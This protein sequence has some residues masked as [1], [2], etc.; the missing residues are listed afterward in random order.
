MSNQ[1][2][3]QS[4]KQWPPFF[5]NSEF[6]IN[7]I[8]NNNNQSEPKEIKGFLNTLDDE[9]GDS[10][11]KI[12]ESTDLSKIFQS[13][14]SKELDEKTQ[15]SFSNLSLEKKIEDDKKIEEEK[16]ERQ[17]NISFN[18]SNGNKKSFSVLFNF[19][20]GKD[21]ISKIDPKKSFND[22]CLAKL[23]YGTSKHDKTNKNEIDM[24]D[25]FIYDTFQQKETFEIND[26]VIVQIPD[27]KLF[28]MTTEED[29]K[30]SF[31]ILG[32]GKIS[33]TSLNGVN[34]IVMRQN[35]MGKCILNTRLYTSIKP[36]ISSNIVQLIAQ[37]ENGELSIYKIIFPNPEKAQLFNNNILSL[38]K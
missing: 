21:F 2:S 26:K 6:F 38:A 33:I 24:T 3:D 34:R 27:T 11:K 30:K 16:K 9:D 35:S 36:K 13:L 4:K 25:A 15:N 7:Q 19:G 10:T 12:D 28:M 17:T 31:V 29:G 22:W 14:T 37:N 8:N 32:V 23:N 5:L 18:F 20:T 1:T